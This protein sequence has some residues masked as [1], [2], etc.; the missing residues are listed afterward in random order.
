MKAALVIHSKTGT[1]LAFGKAI[2]QALQ[3][4]GIETE[5]ILLKFETPQGEDPFSEEKDVILKEIPDCLPYDCILA[6]SPVWV[7]SPTPVIRAFLRKA[8]GLSRKRFFPFIT[9]GLPFKGWGGTRAL[10]AMESIARTM[11]AVTFKGEAVMK[12]GRNLEKQMQPAA[13]RIAKRIK[14]NA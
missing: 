9:M 5:L 6:G 10:R 8:K 11:G 3:K 12:R 2:E 1:T 14:N 7:F 4:E 13:E